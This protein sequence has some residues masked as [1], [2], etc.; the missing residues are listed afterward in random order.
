[1]ALCGI[2]ELFFSSYF[3][4]LSSPLPT[5]VD[6]AWC[7]PR[8]CK[9][10][11][12]HWNRYF[13]HNLSCIKV[14]WGLW[15]CVKLVRLPCFVLVWWFPPDLKSRKLLQGDSRMAWQHF[16]CSA[17]PRPCSYCGGSGP[18]SVMWL[19]WWGAQAPGTP[20]LSLGLA[21]LWSMFHLSH[22]LLVSLSEKCCLWF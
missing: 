15:C 8:L 6:A 11:S 12:L 14:L 13:S 22:S 1:M 5:G 16:L 9:T 2:T 3:L 7:S 18:G 21:L 19:A 20:A 10:L 4:F 17:C